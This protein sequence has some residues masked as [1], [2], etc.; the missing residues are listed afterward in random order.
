MN[1]RIFLV[2]VM[3]CM[4]QQVF[5]VPVMDCMD[6]QGLGLYTLPHKLGTATPA[7]I[8]SLTHHSSHW[9]TKAAV[10]NA[11]KQILTPA[12]LSTA[13]HF[14]PYSSLFVG[15]LLNIPATCERISGTDLHR[16]LY[17]LPHWNRSC[18]SNFPSHPVTVYWHRG[19][20]PSTDPI[21]P[22]AWQGSH[23][24]ANF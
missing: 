7:W 21:T 17:V 1:V 14:L 11:K 18:R 10:L 19:T 4:D 24:S 8:K 15:W 12:I 6:Q 3:D 23:W 22:G 5:T 20:S 9:K 13:L 16:Q 2:P